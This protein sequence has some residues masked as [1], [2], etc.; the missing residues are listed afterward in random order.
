M[1]AASP[2]TFEQLHEALAQSQKYGFLSPQPIDNQIQHSLEFISLWPDTQGEILDLGAGGG[3]PSLVW[4]YQNPEGSITALDAMTKRTNFLE[5]IRN[6]YESITT[7]L[8]IINGRAEEVA[9]TELREKFELVVARGFGPPTI[10]A[11]CASGL[12]RLGGHLV[13]SGRPE[14]EFSRWNEDGLRKLGLT[15][16]E[17]KSSNKAH[18]A[19]IKKIE[20]TSDTYPRKTPA[21]KKTPLWS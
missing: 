18:A 8:T 15:L 9:H 11:E 10:T 7:R 13:V 1:S 4:L 3:L 16:H 6:S 5:D 14:E 21:M 12:L 19:I 2:F 17:V 20:V